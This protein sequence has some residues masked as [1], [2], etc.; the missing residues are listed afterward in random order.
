MCLVREVMV[1][2]V[3]VLYL[4]NFELFNFM[5]LCFLTL[6][7]FSFGHVIVHVQ[8]VIF[9]EI[10][11]LIGKIPDWGLEKHYTSYNQTSFQ[12]HYMNSLYFTHHYPPA[13]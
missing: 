11:N 10:K 9:F 13:L 3:S 2:P 6:V 7:H 8:S 5:Q 12:T 1:N 4:A